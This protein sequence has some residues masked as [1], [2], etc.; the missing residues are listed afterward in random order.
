MLPGALPHIGRPAD[1]NFERLVPHARERG[2]VNVFD[3]IE[4]LREAYL[5]FDALHAAQSAQGKVEKT[6][7]DLLK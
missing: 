5:A 1:G 2:R 3:A 4:K 6:T 7:M